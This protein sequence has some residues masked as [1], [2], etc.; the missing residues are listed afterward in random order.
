[1]FVNDT[2]IDDISRFPITTLGSH[3]HK[4]IET[5]RYLTAGPEVGLSQGV[6]KCVVQP[7]A[8]IRNLGKATIRLQNSVTK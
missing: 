2:N 6:Q 1:V 3:F 7:I 4:R 5:L 8:V